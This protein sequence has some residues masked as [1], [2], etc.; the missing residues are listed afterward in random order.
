MS[1]FYADKNVLI[2][3]G[4]GFVG[5]HLTR[6][7]LGCR[8][9]VTVLDLDTN[10]SRL[11]VVDDAS[12]R[13]NVV[14]IEGDITQPDLT[15]K[16]FH[17]RS[18]DYVFHLASY[19]TAIERAVENPYA[20][21]QS[22]TM[23]TVNLLEA[24]RTMPPERRPRSIVITSTD[25]VY[26]D[27]DGQAYEEDRTPLRGI[28]VY[29]SA[30]LAADVF[31]RTYHEVF[32]LP[33]VVLRMCNIFGPHDLSEYRLVPKAMLRIFGKASPEPP[34]LYFEA[35][36]HSRDYLYVEDA[37]RALL[38]LGSSQN[39]RG[40]VFNLLACKSI[41]TPGMLRA[42]VECAAR[43]EEDPERARTI[44]TNGIRINGF[45]AD[46]GPEKRKVVTIKKQHL[47]GEKI[48]KALDFEPE[49]SFEA[50][51]VATVKSYR[52]LYRGKAPL[53]ETT[54]R[55]SQVA[56]VNPLPAAHNGHTGELAG[57]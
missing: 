41:S 24:V 47:N 5:S 18:F 30:K 27:M 31:A 40:D 14:A 25:K 34:E 46:E 23:G 37:V 20:T 32:G 55:A 12:R 4:C 19:A 52:A 6:A 10:P 7:L 26:G 54:R 51:L 48:R 9:R 22:N 13:A 11:A 16:C 28:G 42:L 21:I 36:D 44:R 3:G 39:C 2:T 56:P 8:A 1:E 29:D 50:A 17:Q 45:Q 38:G 49:M 43:I 57:A 35:I 53:R 15:M 33:T